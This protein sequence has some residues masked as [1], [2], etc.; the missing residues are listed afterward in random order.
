MIRGDPTTVVPE[1]T[2]G[3]EQNTKIGLFLAGGGPR[4]AY[5]V[6]VLKAASELLGHPRESPFPILWRGGAGDSGQRL[7]RLGSQ[8]DRGV[9]ILLL[10]S[11]IPRGLAGNLAYRRAGS[12]ACCRSAIAHPYRF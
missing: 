5:Q 4:A 12:P 8:S 6:A 7:R 9:G 3:N 11:G 10:R 2:A 1:R